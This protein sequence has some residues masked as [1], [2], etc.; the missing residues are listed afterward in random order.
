MSAAKTIQIFLP[1]G[2]PAGLRIAELTTGIVKAIAV[3]RSNLNQFFARPE[4][5]NICT[6]VLFG[7]KDDDAS[8]MAYIGQTEDIVQRLK[9]H[10]ASK[11]FW[12][13][14]VVFISSKDSFH[15]AYIRWLEWKSIAE[16]TKAQ[17][18]TLDNGNAGSEPYVTESIRADVEAIF[19]ACSLLLNALGYPIFRPLIEGSQDDAPNEKLELFLK[20]S[21]FDAKA[22]MTE[23]GFVVRKDSVCRRNIAKSS[24]SWVKLRRDKLIASG[25]LNDDGK[26][27][28]FV[29]DSIFKTPSGASDVV[30]GGSTNGWIEWKDK[31]GRTLKEIKN[32]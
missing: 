18:Y 26:D 22:V 19:E 31:S 27:V 21:G 17:R 16:A 3:P 20:G 2:D 1:D 11:E 23:E 5:K 15:L 12:N 14:V 7:G 24:E 25:C 28:A 29:K 30:K 32:H 9:S 13:T 8:P 10:D 6:Y 4:A